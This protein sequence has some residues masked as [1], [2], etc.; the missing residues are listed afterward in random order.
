[1]CTTAGRAS[2]CVRLLV[3]H[4]L[5]SLTIVHIV[6]QPSTRSASTI[7]QEVEKV[8]QDEN[9][10]LYELSQDLRW[11]MTNSGEFC[12]Y[13]TSEDNKLTY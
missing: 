9:K 2:E 11:Q 12:L 1:M 10:D 6:Q 8:T 3:I 4:V 5:C 13:V 7:L